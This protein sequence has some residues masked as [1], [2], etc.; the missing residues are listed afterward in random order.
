[1]ANSFKKTLYFFLLFFVYLLLGMVIFVAV[2]DDGGASKA[3]HK[4]KMNCL[5]KTT[6]KK[7]NMTSA[8][9]GNLTQKMR[10]LQSSGPDWNYWNAFSFV[11][12]VVTTIGESVE[13]GFFSRRLPLDLI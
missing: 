1:M 7:Y 9:F 5:R 3:R 8:E 4:G 12:Q 2:E 13:N 11:L 10:D 6:M